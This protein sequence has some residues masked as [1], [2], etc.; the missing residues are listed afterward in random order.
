MKIEKVD[1]LQMITLRAP[2]GAKNFLAIAFK[3]STDYLWVMPALLRL[4]AGGICPWL[5]PR[6]GMGG[7]DPPTPRIVIIIITRGGRGGS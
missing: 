4:V 5:V 7:A 6:G 3:K 2:Y 1:G